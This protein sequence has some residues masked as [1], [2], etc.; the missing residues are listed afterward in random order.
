MYFITH[1]SQLTALMAGP[2]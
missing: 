1:Y 2:S